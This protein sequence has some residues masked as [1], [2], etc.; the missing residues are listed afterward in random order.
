MPIEPQVQRCETT[1]PRTFLISRMEGGGA[2]Y[3]GCEIEKTELGGRK[4]HQTKYLEKVHPITYDKKRGTH[5]SLHEREVTQLRG[6]LG[7]LQWPAVQTSPHLQCSTSQL[8]AHVNQGTVQTLADCNRLLK[9]A[10][11]HKDVGL[12]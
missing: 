9:F 4:L 3:C 1:T 6:L 8:A 10:K 11:E 2:E 5:E 12:C 7:S